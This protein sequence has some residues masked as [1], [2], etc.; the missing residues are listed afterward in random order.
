MDA[1]TERRFVVGTDA[2][3]KKAN[4]PA[5]RL[6][7]R[8]RSLSLSEAAKKQL[9][10]LGAIDDFEGNVNI[11]SP[12]DLNVDHRKRKTFK[13]EDE[14]ASWIQ[15]MFL[16]YRSPNT[17]P[18]RYLHHLDHPSVKSSAENHTRRTGKAGREE[19]S[20]SNDM[21]S[22]PVAEILKGTLEIRD[23]IEADRGMKVHCS[24]TADGLQISSAEEAKEMG[25]LKLEETFVTVFEEHECLFMLGTR[26]SSLLSK[27]KTQEKDW[28][29]FACA[30]E[31][32]KKA[33]VRNLQNSGSRLYRGNAKDMSRIK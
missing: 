4:V 24:L 25:N 6:V 20:S 8:D 27:N 26:R 2:G 31:L 29:F 13:D 19:K 30:N 11:E 10:A 7:S 22:A 1:T 18:R 12:F 9:Q 15:D 16:G 3:I 14:M 21:F 17:S 23:S 32:E 28:I 5:L 33:W